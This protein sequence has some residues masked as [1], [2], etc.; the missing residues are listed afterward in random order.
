MCIFC[1]TLVVII[2]IYRLQMT[3]TAFFLHHFM[4][5]GRLNTWL[6]LTDVASFGRVRLIVGEYDWYHNRTKSAW[7]K[8]LSNLEENGFHISVNDH[9][10]EF[11]EQNYCILTSLAGGVFGRHGMRFHAY[12]A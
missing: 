11:D 7:T 10:P 1:I 2:S 12:L 3:G 4:T 6:L 5:I 9:M 8:M